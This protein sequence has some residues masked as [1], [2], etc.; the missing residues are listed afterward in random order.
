MKNCNEILRAIREGNCILLYDC[1]GREEETDMVFAAEYV[2]PQLLCEVRRNAGGLVCVSIH[3][4]IAQKL[5]LPFM[6]DILEL[7]SGRFPVLSRFFPEDVPYGDKPAF[8]ITVN[9]RKTFTGI[10]DNDR[11][12]T[13]RELAKL[14]HKAQDPGV[15]DDVL[16]R[17][18]GSNFRSPGHVHILIAEKNLL[19][20]RRGHTE[21]SI[22]LAELAGLTPAMVICEILDNHTGKALSKDAALRY[23]GNYGLT[24][25]EGKEIIMTYHKFRNSLPSGGIST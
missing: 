3:S 14:A 8:S 4:N 17:E 19:K 6:A 15:K 16:R 13:I 2:T 25:I 9:H 21:L 18:F 23:A 24:F 20:L 10:T 7:A 5:G 1:E 12:L 22:A 11:A